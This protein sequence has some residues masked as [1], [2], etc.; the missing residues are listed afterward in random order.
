MNKD[1]LKLCIANDHRGVEIKN[2][3]LEY[4]GNKGYSV[5]NYGTDS[6]ESAD[7]PDFA[8]LLGKAINEKEFDFGIIICGSG[9]GINMVVNK[10]PFVR[11]AIC[12]NTE[13]AHLARAHNDAN[14]CSLPANYLSAEQAKQIVEIFL[15]AKFEGGRHLRRVNKIPIQK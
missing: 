15:A 14:I 9:N 1:V 7:Y 10:Y 2:S 11:S 8:H 6:L 13:L 4:L 3:L 5:K 12:W